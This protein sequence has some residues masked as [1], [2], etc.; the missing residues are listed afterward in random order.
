MCQNPYILKTALVTDSCD[1]GYFVVS[2]VLTHPFFCLKTALKH[3][4]YQP[5]NYDNI[6]IE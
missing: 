2:A 1:E 5:S 6:N 4:F 3:R